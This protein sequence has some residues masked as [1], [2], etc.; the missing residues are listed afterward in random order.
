[1]P[2]PLLS[3]WPRAPLLAP[4]LEALPAALVAT[5][6]RVPAPPALPA[7]ALLPAEPAAPVAGLPRSSAGGVGVAVGRPIGREGNTTGPTAS[8]LVPGAPAM[9]P[10][11]VAAG[12]Y[13]GYDAATS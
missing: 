4:A 13:D 1:M 5:F 11:M 6:R 10:A 8:A 7:A 3:A 9:M 2:V 12:G